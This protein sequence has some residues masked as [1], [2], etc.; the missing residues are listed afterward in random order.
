MDGWPK[1]NKLINPLACCV[2]YSQFQHFMEIDVSSATSI[3][4]EMKYSRSF[5][6]LFLLFSFYPVLVLS[7]STQ[8]KSATSRFSNE[9]N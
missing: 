7:C 8:G 1:A 3:K 5:F 2:Q 9:F 6:T 4:A